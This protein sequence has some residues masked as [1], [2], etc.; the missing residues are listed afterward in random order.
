MQRCH[1]HKIAVSKYSKS[2]AGFFHKKTNKQKNNNYKE[3]NELLKKKTK[4]FFFNFH[5]L[6]YQLTKFIIVLRCHDYK[7]SKSKFA[8]GDNLKKK[9]IF[10]LNIFIK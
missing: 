6:V 2:T 3:I 10:F 9:N 7:F 8:K 5:Q 1:T 4:Y